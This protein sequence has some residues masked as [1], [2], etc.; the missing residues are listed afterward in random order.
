M[1]LSGQNRVLRTCSW[2]VDFLLICQRCSK[3]SGASTGHLESGVLGTPTA[4]NGIVITNKISTSWNEISF[5]NGSDRKVETP[6]V[7]DYRRSPE[8]GFLGRPR[9]KEIIKAML[10]KVFFINT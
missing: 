3:L 1:S 10:C 2:R 7:E 9:L 5:L 4:V 8:T 6:G